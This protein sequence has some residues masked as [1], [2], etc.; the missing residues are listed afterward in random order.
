MKGLINVLI[1]LAAAAFVL[2][3][4]MKLGGTEP[5]FGRVPPL[6]IWRFTIGCLAFAMTL[7][8]IQIRNYAK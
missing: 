6:T 7:L 1:I 4:V 2:G 5:L 8:L 3:I